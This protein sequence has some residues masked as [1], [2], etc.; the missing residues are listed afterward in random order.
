MSRRDIVKLALIALVLAAAVVLILN[1][2]TRRG[3]EEGEVVRRA[4]REAAVTCFAVEGAYPES[5][6]YLKD[7]Y[8]L[9]WDEDRYVVFYD[10]WSANILPD[11]AVS[12]KGAGAP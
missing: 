6:D 12:A 1:I 2:D 7:H 11:I 5:L 9:S 4:V 8:R 3:R 10:R